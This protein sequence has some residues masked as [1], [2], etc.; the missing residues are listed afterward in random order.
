MWGV[1]RGFV[2]RTPRAHEPAAATPRRIELL[3]KGR[4]ELRQLE[5]RAGV[6]RAFLVGEGLELEDRA[7]DG[8]GRS[9]Q[10]T[11]GV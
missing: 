2:A 4:V 8:P 11:S 7:A 10:A 1:I 9:R 6:G 3:G 5:Q